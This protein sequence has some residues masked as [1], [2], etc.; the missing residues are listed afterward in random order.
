MVS[1]LANFSEKDLTENRRGIHFVGV[2]RAIENGGNVNGGNWQ[3]E[4]ERYGAGAAGW[5]VILQQFVEQ[6]TTNNNTT[7]TT[8]QQQQQQQQQVEEQTAREGH[9]LSS[10]CDRRR[11]TLAFEENGE[12]FCRAPNC[13]S[14]VSRDLVADVYCGNSCWTLEVYGYYFQLP[15]WIH[16]LFQRM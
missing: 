8:L 7:I 13:W 15:S 3:G 2:Q 16:T 14:V 4:R 12:P 5:L 11:R 10:P 6:Q 9:W 1:A